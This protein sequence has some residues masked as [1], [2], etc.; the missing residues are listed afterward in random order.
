MWHAEL[1]GLCTSP[2][3]LGSQSDDDSRNGEEG[4]VE[5]EEEEGDEE[6]SFARDFSEEGDEP[7]ILTALIR[8]G[9]VPTHVCIPCLMMWILSQDPVWWAQ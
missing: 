5:G 9:V 1:T 6:V 2:R 4:L 3:S 8:A 7:L